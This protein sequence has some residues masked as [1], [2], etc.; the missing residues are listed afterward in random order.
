MTI[1]GRLLC[2]LG[3]HRYELAGATWTRAVFVCDRPDCYEIRS[4][5]RE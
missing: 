5:D 3:F 2:R 4:E 1:I